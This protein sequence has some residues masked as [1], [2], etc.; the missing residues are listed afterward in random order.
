MRLQ[1]LRS[2]LRVD[3]GSRGASALVIAAVIAAVVACAL[4]SPV[5]AAQGSRSGAEGAIVLPAHLPADC[6]IAAGRDY[7]VP[8]E[9]LVAIVRFESRGRN[10]A[11]GRNTDGTRDLGVAQHNTASWVPYF[12]KHYGIQPE[13]LRLSPCQ[14]VRAA[15]YSLRWEQNRKECRGASIWC[16]VGRYHSPGNLAL[17]RTYVAGVQS[18]LSQMLET[19]RF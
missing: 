13:D 10:G 6:F 18:A 9:V 7:D 17:R 16:G 5:A 11:V 3:F 1:L 19:G 2:S 15:A 12:Q 4:V 14:S 8:P